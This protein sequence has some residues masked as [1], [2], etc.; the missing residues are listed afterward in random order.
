M[1]EMLQPHNVDVEEAL[2]GTI[3]SDS[4]T[5]DEAI[6]IIHSDD[7]F[8]DPFCKHV[9]Q[10]VVKLFEEGSTVNELTVADKIGEQYSDRL[11]SAVEKA[12]KDSVK[13]FSDIVLEKYMLRSVEAIAYSTLD[14]LTEGSNPFETIEKME[15]GLYTLSDTVNSRK[16]TFS[17][18]ELTKRVIDRIDSIRVAGTGLIGISTGFKLLLYRS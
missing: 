11:K 1:N 13:D 17:F 6:D 2:I 18:G 16:D 10:N 4:D 14:E 5:F 3:V 9:F 7:V 12:K 8:Y 15:S